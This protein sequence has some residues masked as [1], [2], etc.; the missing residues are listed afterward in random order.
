MLSVY[1]LPEKFKPTN[2][3][4]KILHSISNLFLFG[5]ALVSLLVFPK[6]PLPPL[7]VV[8]SPGGH[9]SCGHLSCPSVLVF[10]A[11]KITAFGV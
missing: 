8:T 3:A 4:R 1:L 6:V 5:Q 2:F 11:A 10:R 7:L 9:L